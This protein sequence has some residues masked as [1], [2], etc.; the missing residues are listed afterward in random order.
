MARREVGATVFVRRVLASL[1]AAAAAAATGAQAD[2]HPVFLAAWLAPGN[3]ARH[4]PRVTRLPGACPATLTPVRGWAGLFL[5]V[6][7][8]RGADRI[9]RPDADGPGVPLRVPVARENPQRLLWMPLPKPLEDCRPSIFSEI[10]RDGRWSIFI[11]FF[12]ST[13][14]RIGR[15]VLSP[16]IKYHTLRCTESV[17]TY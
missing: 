5:L 12:L 9:V 13:L 15:T 11:L 16:Q 7:R 6:A 14:D 8:S 17:H 2:D 10:W 1:S 3:C 4:A